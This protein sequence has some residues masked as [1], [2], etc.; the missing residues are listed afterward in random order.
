MT[1][2]TMFYGTYKKHYADCKT[3]KGSYNAE[4]KSIDVVIPDGRMKASG[5]RGKRFRTYTFYFKY[6][7]G[8]N[9]ENVYKAVSYENAEKR[10]YQE[11]KREGWTP[12]ESHEG[13]LVNTDLMEA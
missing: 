11:C 7:N 1:V 4:F 10:Y 5:V 13:C 12:C 3:I 6:A 9:G 2:K 8:E